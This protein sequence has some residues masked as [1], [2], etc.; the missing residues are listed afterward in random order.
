MTDVTVAPSGI[1]GLGIFA[2]RH[3]SRGE[4]IRQIHV[5]REITPDAPLR[6]D[7]GERADHCDYPDGKVVLLG[8]PDRHVNHS[9][10]PSA[11]VVY[12]GET[13]RFV[14]RRDIRPGDEVTIDYNIN[15]SGGTAWPCHCG[16]PRC[17]GTAAG[18]FFLLPR[19]LQLEY[20]PLLADWFVRRHHE[21]LEH[22]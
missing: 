1:D 2:A 8:Y 10:D 19:A 22:L 18:D 15:I 3:F 6:I 9:C 11:F 7:L 17:T 12:V 5:L 13:S 20:R 4:Q 21:R 16:A 14:A